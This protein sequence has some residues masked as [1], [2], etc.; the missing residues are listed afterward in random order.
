MFTWICPKC[1][2]EVP[3]SYSECPNCEVTGQAQ[4][5]PGQTAPSTDAAPPSRPAPSATAT[6]R[7]SRPG[8]PHWLLSIVFAVVFVGVGMGAFML[9]RSTPERQP[10]PA[11]QPAVAMETPGS[12]LA[13]EVEKANPAFKSVELTGLRLTEDKKQKAF[14]Q[15]V[16][17]NHS[18]ADLGDIGARVNLRTTKSGPA[19]PPV[20][21]FTF[22]TSLGPYESK[23][24]KV[25]V[26]T[27]LRVYELPDWQFLR[28][29]IT[30]Q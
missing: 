5:P 21:T 18:G 10:A 29:E 1:G 28:T 4:T 9:F 23:D 20:G 15:F 17:V 27:K 8:I 19:D 16:V 13:P 24:L 6:A 22:K 11:A 30:G 7:P 25:S 12:Q 26:D 2:K 3:P 14:L